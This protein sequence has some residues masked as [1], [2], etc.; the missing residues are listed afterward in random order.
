MIRGCPATH[1]PK[2]DPMDKASTTSKPLSQ[3]ANILGYIAFTLAGLYFAFLSNDP[4]QGP[5]F[6]GLALVFDPYDQSVK[7]SER[8]YWVRTLLLAHC[9]VAII[10]LVHLFLS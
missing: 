2:T 6:L 4:S 10:A 1:A 7:W 3:P 8:P 9:I 5:L